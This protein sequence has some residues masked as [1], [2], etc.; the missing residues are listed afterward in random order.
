MRRKPI[1]F[2]KFYYFNFTILF[3]IGKKP[4]LTKPK[5]N[6]SL[7][8]QQQQ[9]NELT[10]SSVVMDVEASSNTQDNQNLLLNENSNISS[11]STVPTVQQTTTT[12]PPN[13]ATTTTT[14]AIQ[15]AN[16]SPSIQLSVKPMT[17]DEKRQ[18]SLDINKLPGECL[19]KVVQIIQSREPSLRDSNPD[20]IEIDFETLKPSTLR[21]LEL[22]V[23]SVLNN[24]NNY[25]LFSKQGLGGSVSTGKKPRKPYTKRQN[26]T[27]TGG[28]NNNIVQQ[29]NTNNNNNNMNAQVT[30]AEHQ[31]Q[32]EALSQS[33]G[34]NKTTTSSTSNLSSSANAGNTTTN[35]GDPLS[36]TNNTNNNTNKDN[37]NIID[38][39]IKQEL[40]RKLESIQRELSTKKLSQKAKSEA[41]LSSL[42]GGKQT[43]KQQNV[44]S[45][46][47]STKNL[48]TSSSNK[49][50]DKT[51]ENVKSLSDSSSG[52][53]SSSSDDENSNSDD[54]SS[55]S[56]SDSSS[57]SGESSDS[58]AEN[59]TTKTTSA[60]PTSAGLTKNTNMFNNSDTNV[61][62]PKILT[63]NAFI[64]QS[65]QK[66]SVLPYILFSILMCKIFIY[67]FLIFRLQLQILFST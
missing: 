28:I 55:S 42:S 20:E 41:A 33:S 62:Q 36:P 1:F 39:K 19:G 18:L 53:D 64:N 66:V 26:S 47:A 56:S 61:L 10:T 16:E 5:T 27:A 7:P 46:K 29:P 15:P 24:N 58:D 12:T 50:K 31:Q 65:G 35:G 43:S 60:G 4:R 23:S 9:P 17:Y 14:N 52:D 54:D 67:A 38:S 3:P 63:Q 34:A 37:S 11:T 21:E 30:G 44:G 45:S 51:A 6:P 2:I 13:S 8:Q 59:K 25:N 32:D 48:N 40:E 57:S 49:Q 22:Y